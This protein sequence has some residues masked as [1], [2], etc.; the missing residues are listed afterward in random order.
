MFSRLL[1]AA[2]AGLLAAHP[3]LVAGLFEQSA[4]R[5]GLAGEA[6][7]E[8][9][10]RARGRDFAKEMSPPVLTPSPVKKTKKGIVAPLITTTPPPTLA[11]DSGA[12]EQSCVEV[13]LNGR[14]D[15]VLKPDYSTTVSKKGKWQTR[16]DSVLMRWHQE[17]LSFKPDLVYFEADDT[18]FVRVKTATFEALQGY[19][20]KGK[21]KP[22]GTAFMAVI[23]CNEVLLYVLM[24]QQR[25]PHSMKI[26]DANGVVIA[27]MKSDEQRD[28]LTFMSPQDAL[29][30]FAESPQIGAN[31][32]K[33]AGLRPDPDRGG[34]AHWELRV[35]TAG[36]SPLIK[37]HKQWVLGVA[38]QMHA[39]RD[40]ERGPGADGL[41][42]PATASYLTALVVL[43]FVLLCALGL[44]GLKWVFNLVYP[45]RRPG[46][47]K[48]E[49]P[50]LRPPPSVPFGDNPLAK[51][52][53]RQ[54]Q[55]YPTGSE[56]RVG[57]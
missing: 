36:D 49:N 19:G 31:Q 11:P 55:W 15:I 29:I 50:F 44:V 20:Y 47:G 57:S 24:E 43:C 46:P 25:E 8:A 28:L 17:F 16:D 18:S 3:R 39:I 6:I 32:I 45:E 5:L 26:Y 53:Y 9:L 40:S 23:D 14:E 35:N 34:V 21:E 37:P 13:K 33:G 38:V 27:N 2:G 56:R 52:P 48:V 4:H 51:L 1:L 41:Q 22:K 12:E 10:T 7:P 30:G 54:Q 42:L